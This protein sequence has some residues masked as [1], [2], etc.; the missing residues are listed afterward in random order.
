MP[1]ISRRT[2]GWLRLLECWLPLAQEANKLYGWGCTPAD[3]E[4]LILRSAP[5]LALA[6]TPLEARVIL[7]HYHLTNGARNAV[8]PPD[9][10][11]EEAEPL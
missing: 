1:D 8:Q 11:N 10:Q 7:W 5:D 3:L 6:H 4:A 2:D 9:D